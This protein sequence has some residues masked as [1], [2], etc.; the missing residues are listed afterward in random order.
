MLVQVP[1]GNF[2]IGGVAPLDLGQAGDCVAKVRHVKRAC[3]IV[4]GEAADRLTVGK[5]LDY[6]K[7]RIRELADVRPAPGGRRRVSRGDHQKSQPRKNKPYVHTMTP[8]VRAPR[9][10]GRTIDGPA[11]L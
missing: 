5:S 2:G 7:R 8:R 9:H 10:A 3:G 6:G 4:M 11:A 1:P